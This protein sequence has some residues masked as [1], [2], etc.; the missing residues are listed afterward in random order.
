MHT[1]QQKCKPPG[2]KRVIFSPILEIELDPVTIFRHTISD[3][4]VVCLQPRFRRVQY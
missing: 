1:E 2:V 3:L 4:D